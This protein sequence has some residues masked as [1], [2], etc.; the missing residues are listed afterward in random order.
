MTKRNLKAIRDGI[1]VFSTRNGSY[2]AEL[3]ALIPEYLSEIPAEMV[4]K[5]AKS[6]SEPDGTGGWCYKEGAVTVNLPGK[7]TRGRFYSQW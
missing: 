4:T 2:P 1:S 3:P 6:V 5:S 7:D